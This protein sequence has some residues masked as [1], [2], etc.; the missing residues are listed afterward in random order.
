MGNV[1]VK[2]AGDFSSADQK[3]LGLYFEERKRGLAVFFRASGITPI[4]LFST[5]ARSWP[6]R[7]AVRSWR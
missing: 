6:R 1:Y 2:D 4:S 7:T 3:N 5:T